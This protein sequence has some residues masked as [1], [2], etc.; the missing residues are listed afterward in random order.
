MYSN[1]QNQSQNE[2]SLQNFL[3]RI[4]GI[5]SDKL[6]ATAKRLQRTAERLERRAAELQAKADRL[7]RPTE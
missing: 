2:R 7:E 4:F 1:D 3:T 6:R 5:S